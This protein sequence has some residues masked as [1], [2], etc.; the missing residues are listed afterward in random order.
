M[1]PVFPQLEHRI[2]SGHLSHCSSCTLSNTGQPLVSFYSG[3]ALATAATERALL[4]LDPGSPIW[5]LR[6]FS[7]VLTLVPW[8]IRD[9]LP[10]WWHY[11]GLSERCLQSGPWTR[12]SSPIRTFSH[13]PSN[14]PKSQEK[15][16]P[17]L[18]N[19]K[20][21]PSLNHRLASSC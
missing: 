1:C 12:I 7:F 21:I 19:F 20:H 18:G 5:Q 16:V 2:G 10:H 11:W 4:N 15:S 13:G 9:W 17:W 6:M 14:G 8:S 3:S